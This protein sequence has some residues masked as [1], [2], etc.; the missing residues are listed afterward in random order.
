MSFLLSH[1]IPIRNQER[2]PR[3]VRPVQRLGVIR[4]AA[5]GE[6][7]FLGSPAFPLYLSAR[8]EGRRRIVGDNVARA[9]RYAGG[10]ERD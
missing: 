9:G 10:G 1:L 6:L 7:P 3:A 4:L 2:Y 5:P 8:G